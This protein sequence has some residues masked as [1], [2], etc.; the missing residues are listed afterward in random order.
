MALGGSFHRATAC[1]SIGSSR[2]STPVADVAKVWVDGA[3]VVDVAQTVGWEF[4]TPWTSFN[5]GFTHFQ[6]LPADA[7]VY[8]DDFALDGAMIPC[9]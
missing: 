1:S 4:A 3:V 5:F 7:D 8:L 6:T 2:R 9:P